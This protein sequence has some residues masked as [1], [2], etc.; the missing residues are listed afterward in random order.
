MPHTVQQTRCRIARL[1]SILQY[2]VA[3]SGVFYPAPGSDHLQ[4]V[5]LHLTL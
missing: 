4:L 3:W 2:Q 5:H 1:D